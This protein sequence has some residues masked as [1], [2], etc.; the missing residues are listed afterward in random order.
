MFEATEVINLSNIASDTA[1]PEIDSVKQAE[2]TA[3]TLESKTEAKPKQTPIAKTLK[4]APVQ[5]ITGTAKELCSKGLKI[6][7]KIVDPV[8]LSVM[9]SCGVIG[10]AG[11]EDKPQHQKGKAATVY[12]IT[13]SSHL[14]VEINEP[15]KRDTINLSPD[16]TLA[17]E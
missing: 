11:K 10:I 14:K 7:G 17:K 1:K 2:Q 3:P 8:G 5:A 15:P 13:P 16:V 12:E 4:S 9:S 6:N